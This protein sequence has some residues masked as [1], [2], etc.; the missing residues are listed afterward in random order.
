M[1]HAKANIM[2]NQFESTYSLLV[3]S[4]EKGRGMLEILVY[5]AFFLSVVLS[6][7]Q[8]AGT[9]LKLPAPGADPY[10]ACRNTTTQLRAG[11]CFSA[12]A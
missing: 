11:T 10:V 7:L 5:A 1:R 6:I 3:R 9:S 2:N 12:L 4:E 8:F